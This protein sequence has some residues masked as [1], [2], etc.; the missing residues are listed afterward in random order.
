ML[1]A[2]LR[3]VFAIVFVLVGLAG[4]ASAD[5][6][7]R[8]VEIVNNTGVTIVAFF[9][10]HVDAKTWEENIFDGNVLPSGRSVVVNFDDGTGYCVF[11][12]RAEFA[13]GDVLEEPDVNICEI[14]TYTYQ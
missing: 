1:F 11:D 5:D 13:D 8:R 12:L 3:G 14:G 10:S 2:R 4:G 7:D 6:L 9:G